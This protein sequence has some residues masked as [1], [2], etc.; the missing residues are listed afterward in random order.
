MRLEDLIEQFVARAPG[1]S[2]P[3]QIARRP[4][5]ERPTVVNG[6]VELLAHLSKQEQRI[7]ALEKQVEELKAKRGGDVS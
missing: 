2:P 5:S 4:P 3:S 7:Q 1:E 6:M